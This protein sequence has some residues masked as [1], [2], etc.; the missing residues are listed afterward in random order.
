MNITMDR[1]PRAALL[2]LVCALAF[3][4]SAYYFSIGQFHCID[5]DVSIVGILLLLC[6]S[7]IAGATAILQYV[8]CDKKNASS[9]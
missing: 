8:R 2:S 1:I 3:A 7:V 5:P 9:A 6:T 4:I